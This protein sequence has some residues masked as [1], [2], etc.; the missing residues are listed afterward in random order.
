M[1]EIST[2]RVCKQCGAPLPGKGKIYCQNCLI[3]RKHRSTKTRKTCIVCGC[4]FLGGPSAKRCPECQASENKRWYAEY[5]RA[6]RMGLT[7]KLGN[8]YNCARCGKEYT[9]EAP[10]QKYCPDCKEAAYREMYIKK[11]DRWRKSNPEKYKKSRTPKRI[12]V[13]CGKQIDSSHSDVTCG[14]PECKAAR[15][16]QWDAQAYAKRV[17]KTEIDGYKITKKGRS[18]TKHDE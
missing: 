17:Y 10:K 18:L 1:P 7:R 2:N 12:C 9:L 15:Q 4:E 3:L 8:T 13:I 16:A 11:G 5:Q 14:S 6:K